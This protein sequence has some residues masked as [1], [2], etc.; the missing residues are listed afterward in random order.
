MATDPAQPTADVPRTG[1]YTRFELELE[2]VQCLANPAYL[3]FLATQKLY[4]KPDFV[5]YLAYLQYFKEPRYAKFLHHP[6]PTLW[7]LELLQQE[8]FRREILNPGLM[9]KLVVEG[10]RNAVPVQQD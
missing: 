9:Q 10:Q 8:R 6:G 5:A 1:G 7:A 3:N 4:E 2:F